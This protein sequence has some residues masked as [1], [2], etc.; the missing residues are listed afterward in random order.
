MKNESCWLC[1]VPIGL[2]RNI[3]QCV[4]PK[5]SRYG[6]SFLQTEADG[7]RKN[8]DWIESETVPVPVTQ[9]S[10]RTAWRTYASAILNDSNYLAGCRSEQ[11]SAA[12]CAR[13]GIE[14]TPESEW[15]RKCAA[16]C[17]DE[18]L[19]LENERFGGK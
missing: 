19:K 1:D 15:I 17:A 13:L 6:R 9:D 7:G 4:N 10:N 5:C 3:G 18:M 2:V 14:F 12:T 8:R 16:E 11:D